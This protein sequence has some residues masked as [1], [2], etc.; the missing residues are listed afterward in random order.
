MAVKEVRTAM[1]ACSLLTAAFSG[2]VI[3]RA[4]VSGLYDKSWENLEIMEISGD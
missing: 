3:G 1:E 2:S 4:D